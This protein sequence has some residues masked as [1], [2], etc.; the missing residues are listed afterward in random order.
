V[1]LVMPADDYAPREVEWFEFY[2]ADGV[3]LDA[4]Q[5]ESWMYDAG[6]KDRLNEVLGS[7]EL[8]ASTSDRDAEGRIRVTVA[9]DKV[10]APEN[11]AQ[12]TRAV[13]GVTEQCAKWSTN[14]RSTRL[15]T[16]ATTPAHNN[17]GGH[18]DSPA[19]E[20]T[21]TMLDELDMAITDEQSDLADAAGRRTLRQILRLAPAAATSSPG[22]PLG[23]L[24]AILGESVTVETGLTLL[25][26]AAVEAAADA[27]R[28]WVMGTDRSGALMIMGSY[29]TALEAEAVAAA[30]QAKDYD[31]FTYYVEDQES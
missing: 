4:A 28:F 13:A 9:L 23:A 10:Q 6:G 2:D 16:V 11:T 5:A 1:L 7:P 17:R 21:A 31:G 29:A 14:A 3:E 26:A 15:A 20:G 19:G 22:R 18:R 25:A 8:H 12:I 27:K 30:R 24:G